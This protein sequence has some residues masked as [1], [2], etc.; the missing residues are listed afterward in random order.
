MNL[1]DRHLLLQRI[2]RLLSPGSINASNYIANQQE[3]FNLLF[4]AAEFE[5]DG[6]S[7]LTIASQGYTVHR[8]EGGRA[9]VALDWG[10]SGGGHGHPD[11][12]NLVVAHGASR[13]LD[14]MGTGSYVDPSLHWYRS[15][16]AHNAPLV[17]GRSQARVNGWCVADESAGAFDPEPFSL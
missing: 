3:A 15:T 16:L 2:E 1:L 14:D 13:W 11:R 5:I 8:R 9:Y 7:S 10:E 17:D 6:N 12:L 4:K